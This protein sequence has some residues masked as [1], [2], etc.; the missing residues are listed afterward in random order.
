MHMADR[1]DDMSRQY[2]IKRQSNDDADVHDTLQQKFGTVPP[3][4]SAAGVARCPMSEAFIQANHFG[5]VDWY[6][7]AALSQCTTYML[8]IA[9]TVHFFV[10]QARWSKQHSDTQRCTSCDGSLIA[11]TLPAADS[12]VCA[13]T[14]TATRP[15]WSSPSA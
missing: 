11:T 3:H 5:G 1:P 6:R 7:R 15:K 8:C 9:C 13:E 14:A 4:M 10:V 12:T 2:A